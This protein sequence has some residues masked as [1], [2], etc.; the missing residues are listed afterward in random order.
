MI[1]HAY[2]RVIEHLVRYYSLEHRK[3]RRSHYML[4]SG[5]SS[6]LKS[7]VCSIIRNTGH[8]SSLGLTLSTNLAI[9]KTVTKSWVV[10]KSAYF[11][12]AKLV[13][14]SFQGH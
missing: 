9:Q 3:M 5:S 11:L 14:Y 1:L 7:R 4:R 12:S 6:F 8:L 2:G 13:W 10:T